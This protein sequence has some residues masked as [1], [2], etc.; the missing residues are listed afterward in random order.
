MYDEKTILENRLS[1]I[2][3]EYEAIHQNFQSTLKPKLQSYLAKP[4]TVSVLNSIRSEITKFLRV[5]DLKIKVSVVKS[6]ADVHIIGDTLID[7]IV[8]NSIVE[9]KII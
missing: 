8:W 2:V 3:S 7:H 5:H 4:L 9:G 1:M 6:D